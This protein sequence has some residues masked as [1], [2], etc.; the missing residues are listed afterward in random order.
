MPDI[1]ACAS[2]ADCA[3]A[4]DTL[5]CDT[6]KGKCVQ[7]MSDT[8]CPPGFTC[9]EQR[10][11]GC[12]I[13]MD[14]RA[15]ADSATRPAAD[16]GDGDASAGPLLTCSKA[17]QRCTGC[18]ADIDCPPGSVCNPESMLCNPG[19]TASQHCPTGSWCCDKKCITS[20][21]CE[22]VCPT[23]W[24]NCNG[25]GADGCETKLNALDHC[26]KCETSCVLP[27]Q[28]TGCGPEGCMWG[29]C[30]DGFFD[31]NGAPWGDGCE[32]D[33]RTDINNCGAC[34]K[35][36][37]NPHGP[38]SC[39]AQACK[40][41]CD[42]GFDS[43]GG[44]PAEGCKIDL[45]NDA[46]N[47]GTCGHACKGGPCVNGVC[48]IC[49]DEKLTNNTPCNDSAITCGPYGWVGSMDRLCYCYCRNSLIT[50]RINN[51]DGDGC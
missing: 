10:C 38:T 40:P 48:T 36:C 51:P 43:C 14:C 21:K 6:A 19:C 49:P 1:R 13:D 15:D 46:A 28:L 50:C 34:N 16:A 2:T 41:V 33:G 7:C 9:N 18:T 20:D 8:D 11:A 25:V 35:H 23:G 27:N 12:L 30:N 4:S 22:P 5:F 26:G 39:V 29:A 32:V 47:C 45:M 37:V 42:R 31:C 44:D 3:D 17:N 24:G